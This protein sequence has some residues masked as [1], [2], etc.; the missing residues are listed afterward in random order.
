MK[1]KHGW[2]AISQTDV[3]IERAQ[4]ADEG[5][6]LSQ[7]EAEF[8]ALDVDTVD[9]DPALRQ[10]ANALFD[11]TVLLPAKTGFAFVEPSALAEIR[12]VLPPAPKQPT[13][14][15]GKK[16]L[17]DKAYGAWVGRCAGCM[18]GKGVEGKRRKQMENYLKSQNKWPLTY[19]WSNQAD[20]QVRKDNYF[21][22]PDH[23]FYVENLNCM[24]EDDDTNY[25]AAGLTLVQWRGRDFTPWDAMNHWLSNFPIT[26][27]CTAERVAYRNAVDCLPTPNPDG[28]C[29][30]PYTTATF[31]N[32]YREWI[33]AQIR[34]DFFGYCNPANL[35]R[36]AE[37]AWRDACISHIKNGIYG[38][39]WVAAMLAA[40]YVCDDVETVIRAGL[41][42]VPAQSRLTRDIEEVFGWRKAGLSYEQVVEAIHAKWDE[43][44]AHHWCH[45]N[46][47]AQ[48]VALALL[49]GEKDFGRTICAAVMPG[50]DTD[51][52]GAT[53]G[54]VLGLIL[55][56]K[57]LPDEWAAP[58]RD[59][60]LTGF[61][62]YHK[63]KLGT[64]AKDT[65]KVIETLG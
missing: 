43:A 14:R 42:Q 31:R 53:S 13:K 33:G 34:G 46:S 55:G 4:C 27:V 2:L 49:W 12:Q 45:T 51:C 26:H 1:P 20:E 41:S 37:F 15:P 59:T 48:I 25:T 18:L 30:E 47:N 3:K 57:N 24:V 50:F 7:F 64:M 63:V 54:S 40:A 6:D 10:R 38:E 23:P 29:A 39:M 5:K 22:A 35:A 21:P 58:L 52:N 16:T 11:K 56:R 8:A 28:S 32:P 9:E 44:S 36:A 19:Y 17:L 61:T 60:L 65:V 62:G